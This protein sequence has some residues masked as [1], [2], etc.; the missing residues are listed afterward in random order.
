[1]EGTNRVKGLDLLDRMP[2]EV[3]MAV[4]NTVQE[5]LKTIPKEKKPQKVKMAV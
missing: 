5:V 3:W 2:E 4:C 1:M